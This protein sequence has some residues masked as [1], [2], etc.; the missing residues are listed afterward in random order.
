[1][2]AKPPLPGQSKTRLAAQLGATSASM[3]ARA[4]FDDTWARVRS[5][6][7]AR[8]VLASTGTELGAFGLTQG[9]LWSQGEGDLG[10]RLERV[11]RLALE[12]AP[13]V[14]AIGADCPTMPLASLE[15]ARAG[16][17]SHDAVLGPA[18][19]GGYYLIGL[20][21][22]PPELLSGLPWSAANTLEATR[23]RLGSRGLTV[24]LIEAGF[25]VDEP[26]DLDRLCEVL[27]GDPSLAPQTYAALR[28]LGFVDPVP[29]RG[30]R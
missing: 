18:D 12:L 28:S 5:L 19:D 6:S 7:W 3:I 11:M 15:A 30:A 25:D 16:L 13:W 9:E 21:R 8:A 23:E 29:G 17:V 1:M 22:V 27:K 14:I 4:F 24:R 10:Q 2:I 20:R 26:K